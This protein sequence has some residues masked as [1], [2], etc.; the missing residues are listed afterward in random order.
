MRRGFSIF[1]ILLFGFG[2][3]SVF[4]DSEDA[5][6]PVCC[7]RH[8]EHHCAMAMRM[9]RMMRQAQSGKTPVISPPMTC[10]Y[11][12]GA[13]TAFSAPPLALTVSLAE[14]PVFAELA[15][16]GVKVQTTPSQVPSRAHAGRGPP[17]V[18]Q[19]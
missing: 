3:L 17:A 9:A 4:I 12:P 1:L 19:S 7:R 6:L 13:A 11:Y 5:N 2:P 14:Q 15:R 16:V 8:G 10:P 18:N